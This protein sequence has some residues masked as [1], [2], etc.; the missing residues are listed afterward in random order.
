MLEQL[1][2]LM[3]T[4]ANSKDLELIINPPPLTV[5]KLI[6]DGLRLQQVLINL[7]SNA[8]KFTERGEVELSIH[9]EQLL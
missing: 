7:L 1:A 9:V 5:D 2:V 8:I 4:I 6:G 3:S